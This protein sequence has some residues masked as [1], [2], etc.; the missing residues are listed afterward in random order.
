MDAGPIRVA[1]QLSRLPAGGLIDRS[2]TL[3]FTFDGRALT[4]H[5]GDTLAS[6]LLAN[7][8]RLVGRSFKYHRPRGVLATGVEEPNALME[9]GE[10]ARRRPNT[11]ATV[12]ELYEGLA[13]TSQNRFP[14]LGWD[15]LSANQWAAPWLAAGFYYKTFMWPRR[16]WEPVYEKLIRRAAGLGRASLA[17]D[18]DHYEATHAHCDVLV[19][20]G[21]PAGLMAA[22]TAA[23]AGARVIL[24][25]EDSVLGGRLLYDRR[26][27]DGQPAEA[28]A[29]EVAAELASLPDV[30]V[31]TRTSVFGV[32]DGGTY[33]LL[34]RVA[35]HMAAPPPHVP[36]L[37]SWRVVAKR[38]VLAAGAIER[39]LVFGGND[40]PG[41]MLAGAARAY[42]NRYAVRLGARA[43]VFATHDDAAATARDLG[44]AGI[45]VMAIVDPRPESSEAMRAAADAT[46]ARL[47]AGAVVQDVAGSHAVRGVTVTGG[48]KLECDV[49]A[50]SGGWNPSVQLTT[51]LGG[52]PVWDEQLA[53]FVPGQLPP[54][55]TVAGAGGGRFTLADSLADGAREGAFAAEAC[56]RSPRLDNGPVAD[57]E[58][59]DG[60]P[61]WRVRGGRGR[62]FVDFQNDVS[63]HD[64]DQAHQEG[65][66]RVEHLKRYTTLGMATDEGKTANVVGLAMM[67]ELT[68]QS[69][70]RTGTTTSRP[71]FAPIELGALA[72][73]GVGRHL[74][75]TRLTPTHA[76]ASG[77]GA[78]FVETGLWL[79]ASHYPRHDEDWL[80]AATREAVAVREGAGFCDVSTL[81]KIDVQGPD[82][83]AFLDRVYTSGWQNL[84]VGRVRYGLMLRED[85]FVFDDGTCARLGPTQYVLTT[86]T[87]QAVRVMAHLEHARQWLFRELDVSLTSVTEQWAQLA[88]AGPRSRDILASVLDG[89]VELPFMGCARLTVMG[90]VKARLFRISFSGERA[91][92]LAV[93]S[94]HG[95]ALAERLAAAGATPYGLEALNMLR[96]EKGHPAG[97]ELNG[98]T[99]AHD[100]RLQK[101]LSTKK[102][103]IGR[104][105]AARPALTDPT[106]QTLVG[107]RPL[108]YTARFDGGA[109]LLPRDGEADAAHDQGHVTSVAYSPALKQWIGLGLL[110]NGAT[111]VGEVIR[112]ADPLRGRELLAEVC[113]PVF[114][115]P[116][117]ERLRG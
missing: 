105:M 62:A 12:A 117:G 30:R 17:A 71:P 100:L 34:E 14:S 57:P 59:A 60:V 67:A 111:R 107:L 16:L 5:P 69:I 56:G 8:V 48:V 92:E 20:G 42:V 95:D 74:R 46:G 21:G 70:P 9:V 115:D 66:R 54:G 88:I 26:T 3:K 32:Y 2:R 78:V 89:D 75:P 6:A 90:G 106:R 91:Y 45:T 31:L 52:R 65:F 98:Q 44:D 37:R 94:R 4:G 64:I 33:G 58:P 19:V 27:I 81:G 38:C 86:T 29:A 36:R 11:R 47:L 82:A 73:H 116:A 101:L 109:H 1:T 7:G 96:I 15:L 76:W 50:M 22:R 53:A 61:L 25:E 63:D 24:A 114:V 108:D 72:G 99:T 93:P 110:A 80:A 49:L 112:L 113:E 104:A 43:V 10:G 23:R 68:R 35:D 103:F 13:A 41:V 85:G 83:A 28:W 102:D 84:A 40:R 77:R 55:L 51:H 18:P 39:P 79:R 87:A 97:G